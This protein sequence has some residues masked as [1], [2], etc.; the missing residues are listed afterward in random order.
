MQGSSRGISMFFRW[1]NSIDCV[2][3]SGTIC[4][5]D[6]HY[7]IALLCN[8]CG[9]GPL[10]TTLGTGPSK[11]YTFLYSDYIFTFNT[12][13]QDKMFSK[14]LTY[15]SIWNTPLECLN[16]LRRNWSVHK[17]RALVTRL[18]SATIYLLLLGDGT[19]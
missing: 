11:D 12:I 19:W 4:I 18:Y 15:I 10:Q 1:T 2:W 13:F 14:T 9:V 16:R 3:A 7:F 5:N 6:L 17:P 8:P